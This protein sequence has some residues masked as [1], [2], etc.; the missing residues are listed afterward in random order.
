MHKCNVINRRFVIVL[1]DIY[2]KKIEC[3]C[4]SAG[5]LSVG[6]LRGGKCNG[7]SRVP[8]RY[9]TYVRRNRA[10]SFI[11]I[12]QRS[13]L[14]WERMRADFQVFF[15]GAA[16]RIEERVCLKIYSLCIE[17]QVWNG[18]FHRWSK[19]ICNWIVSGG[20]TAQVCNIQR[21]GEYKCALMSGNVCVCVCLINRHFD[22]Y[23]RQT[24]KV[25]G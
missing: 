17:F 7:I 22:L 3:R 20:E 10:A 4:V 24:H 16:H 25:Y 13:D 2:V 9:S 5:P 6:R 19:E 14:L 18:T 23:S 12:S 21:V 8:L 1:Y 11:F 15:F